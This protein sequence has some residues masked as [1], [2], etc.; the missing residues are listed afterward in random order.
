MKKI[1]KILFGMITVFILCITSLNFSEASIKQD[2]KNAVKK[3]YALM[4]NGSG[5]YKIVDINGDK[6]KDLLWIDTSTGYYKVYTYRN[7]KLK[8]LKKFDYCRGGNLYYNTKK[9]MVIMVRGLFGGRETYVYTAQKNSLKKISKFTIDYEATST[10]K[11][12]IYR[13]N[14]KKVSKSKYIKTLSTLEKSC[15][16]VRP[17]DYYIL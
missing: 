3:Y 8:C 7:S 15:K 4:K 2:Q 5:D 16:K 9:H 10:G 12:T 17:D 14:G 11:K 1:A 13:I 6:V